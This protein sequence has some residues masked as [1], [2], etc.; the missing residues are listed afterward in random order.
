LL[1]DIGAARPWDPGGGTPP[2]TNPGP[3]DATN[4]SATSK[5]VQPGIGSKP[6]RFG[7]VHSHGNDFFISLATV[8]L[9]V[10]TLGRRIRISALLMAAVAVV[11]LSWKVPEPENHRSSTIGPV[12]N[13]SYLRCAPHYVAPPSYGTR[14]LATNCVQ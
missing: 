8:S 5:S 1:R 13:V 10:R 11:F 7:V 9:D 4:P 2:G 6:K 12:E 3:P 14:A